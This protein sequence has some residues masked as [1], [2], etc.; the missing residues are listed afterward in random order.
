MNA[1]IMSTPDPAEYW[2]QRLQHAV[3]GAAGAASERSRSTFVDLACHYWSMY[4]MV[5]GRIR[6][7]HPQ[8]TEFVTT[9]SSFPPDHRCAA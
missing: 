7:E 6:Q 4:M 9:M 8:G 5:H 1:G 3:D 2:L